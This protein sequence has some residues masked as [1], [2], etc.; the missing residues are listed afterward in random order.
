MGTLHVHFCSLL[1]PGWLRS[2]RMG[3]VGRDH[4]GLSGP[5]SVL[6]QGRPRAHGTGWRPDGSGISPASK[7]CP[8]ARSPRSEVLPR[9]LVELLGISSFPFLLC[10]CWS[11]G[12]VPGPCSEQTGM[13]LPLSCLCSGLNSPTFLSLPSSERCS[14]CL[15]NFK[16]LHWTLGTAGITLWAVCMVWT[17]LGSGCS[18]SF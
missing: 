3:Q 16:S 8:S 10:H 18:C 1:L 12:A 4:C 7:T 13:M 11:Q 5:T 14:S 17:R 6:Q 9:A 2:H 15:N